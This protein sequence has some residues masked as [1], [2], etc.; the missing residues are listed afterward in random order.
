MLLVVSFPL[1]L[2]VGL[3][4][5]RVHTPH[6]LSPL[7]IDHTVLLFTGER[8]RKTDHGREERWR[9]Q[10]KNGG[11]EEGQDEKI[12]WREARGKK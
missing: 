2:L 4:G 5:L 7:P 1:G 3:V 8:E 10:K 9:Q 6:A 11:G 12:K